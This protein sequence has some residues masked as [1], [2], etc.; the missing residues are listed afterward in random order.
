V[1]VI[2]KSAIESVNQM[3]V[4]IK[5]LFS[6]A[7]VALLGLVLYAGSALAQDTSSI[8]V[9]TT[10]VTAPTVPVSTVTTATTTTRGEQMLARFG[11]DGFNQMIAR[12]TTMHGA[13]VTAQMLAQ[14]ATAVDCPMHDGTMAGMGMMG[15]QGM[16]GQ[17]GMMGQGRGMMGHGAMAQRD[18]GGMMSGAQQRGFNMMRGS[19]LPDWAQQGLH[20]F[21]GWGMGRGG[22]NGGPAATK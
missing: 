21:I 8:P 6:L 9:V 22:A 20:N 3:K 19:W 5:Q 13:T 18:M 4:Q 15:Q 2:S 16:T 7:F 17:P 10:T 14:E 11:Q 12:M 1:P